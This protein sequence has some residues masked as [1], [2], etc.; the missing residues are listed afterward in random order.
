[1]VLP[2]ACVLYGASDYANNWIGVNLMV[3]LVSMMV[4][5]FAYTVSRMLPTAA[6][7]RVTEITKSEFS[8][9]FIS[10]IIIVA[11]MGLAQTACNISASMSQQITGTSQ[12]PFQYADYYIGNLATN[13]GV[14]LLTNL[15][16]VSL[17]YSI[18]GQ[19]IT[20][21]GASLANNLGITDALSTSKNTFFKDAF[22]NA[23][24]NPD[25]GEP[26]KAFISVTLSPTLDF[27]TTYTLL[28]ELYIVVFEPI[29]IVTTGMLLVQY[30]ALPLLQYSAFA[31]VLPVALALRS[32]SFAG[33]GLRSASNALLAIAIAG[34]IVYPLTVGFDS[35]I[36][37]WIFSASNPSYVYL[38]GTYSLST[39]TPSQFFSG[40]QL[41]SNFAS[42]VTSSFT[43]LPDPVSVL[44]QAQ[45][46]VNQMAQFIFVG[47]ML[48]ALNVAITVG[49]ARGLSKALDGGIEGATQFWSTL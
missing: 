22:G 42:L 36:I 24:I 46:F 45:S 17:Q 8:Q 47:I 44:N 14:S 33:G 34:Y 41:P 21:T 20:S 29:V 23:K 35:Y 37:N 28:S 5:A 13:T 39:I 10:I 25:T 3:I 38:Q 15:Y 9:V 19:I 2:T 6:R 31:I 49:F 30:L 27:G 1:M 26:Y 11:M 12:G 40:M 48:F 43:S 32:L 7:A 4:I 18:Y 16:S